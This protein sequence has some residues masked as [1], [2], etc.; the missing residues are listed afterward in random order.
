VSLNY[1]TLAARYDRRYLVNDYSGVE[2]ALLVF[3]GPDQTRR[4]LEVGCGTGHWMKALAERASRV[5]GL[6]AS[7]NMLAY[8]RSK[9]LPVL[10][11]QGRAEHL[12]FVEGAFDRLFC[13]NA[14]HHFDDKPGF[15]GEARR[16]LRAGGAVMTIGLDPHVGV[17]RWYIYEYFEPVLEIDKR[18]S[19]STQQIR[20][21]MREAR[22]SNVRTH[23]VQ[24]LS[25][26][27]A[28]TTAFEEGRLDRDATSQLAILSDEQYQRGMNR[29]HRAIESAE[30]SGE[31]LYL[32]ADLRL[33]ATYGWVSP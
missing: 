17:D 7:N 25:T 6:D 11:A 12:P 4:V 19:V 2:Q 27:L 1:D 28:A 22:F 24:H 8:A 9:A 21:W 14:F 29:I 32:S 10:L 20:E 23:E 33:Y 3:V 30:A 15:L 5:A 16:V 13:I 18:R 31:T 26:H